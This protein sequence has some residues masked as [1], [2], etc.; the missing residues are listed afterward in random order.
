MN[1]GSNNHYSDL[2]SRYSSKLK[3][4]G[5]PSNIDWNADGKTQL[6]GVGTPSKCF[7]LD[8]FFDT[9]NGPLTNSANIKIFSTPYDAELYPPP[10]TL[11]ESDGTGSSFM[12]WPHPDTSPE[13]PIVYIYSSYNGET[14]REEIRVNDIDPENATYT[15]M[16]AYQIFNDDVGNKFEIGT[17]NGLYQADSNPYVKKDFVALCNHVR[18]YRTENG[19]G[20]ALDVVDRLNQHLGFQTEP[21]IYRE[22][23][24]GSYPE[25]RES[26]PEAYGGTSNESLDVR[27]QDE[28]YSRKVEETKRAVEDDTITMGHVKDPLQIKL[29]QKWEQQQMLK[30]LMLRSDLNREMNMESVS[31]SALMGAVI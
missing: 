31:R 18:E 30:E 26:V 16:M 25:V 10:D 6:T 1:I 12:S 17:A 27:M 20:Q 23:S 29:E 13:D 14:R 11:Q 4:Q 7:N 9:A 19:I 5:S 22:H 8:K 3:P 28:D 21:T 15:E 24:S 2:S